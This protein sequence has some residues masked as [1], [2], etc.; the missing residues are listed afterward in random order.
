MTTAAAV[1][2][3][4]AVAATEVRGSRRNRIAAADIQAAFADQ[5]TEAEQDIEVGRIDTA[6]DIV[7]LVVVVVVVVAAGT[8]DTAAVEPTAVQA[9]ET[10]VE[11]L[12]ADQEQPSKATV[13]VVVV[14]VVAA[15]DTR[16]LEKADAR[17][18]AAVAAEAAD[19]QEQ[20]RE[21]ERSLLAG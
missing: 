17:C 4:V 3:V 7:Q 16:I 9:M 20:E 12:Q 8:V 13:L 11:E 14:V 19:N 15:A 21:G 6:A 1:V 5:D 2:V 18:Q 10:A